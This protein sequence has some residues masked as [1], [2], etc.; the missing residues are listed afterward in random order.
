MDQPIFWSGPLL[1]G[2]LTWL[3]LRLLAP[4]ATRL[5]LLD[6]PVGRKDH[7]H[8]TPITGGIAMAVAVVVAGLTTLTTISQAF[9]GFMAAGL[10]LVI[11]GLLDDKYDLRWWIRV[12]AQVVAA[13][14][15]V[16][17]GDV[18]VLEVSEAFGIDTGWSLGWLSVP[19]TV[20]ATVGLINAVNMV[21]GVDGLAGSL[22][23]AALS[24]F[25]VAALYSGNL[26][27]GERA[28]VLAGAVAGFLYYNLRMPWR[29]KAT[30]FMGNAGSA[31]LGFAIAWIAF[32]L[33]QSPSH[34]VNPVL[35]LWLVPVP[36]MDCLVLL[37]R[38]ARQRKSPFSADRDHIHHLMLD[39]GFS[40]TQICG[41]LVVF[42]G[43]CGLVAGQAMRAN[44]PHPVILATFLVMCMAWYWTTSRRVRAVG[45]L[46]SVHAHGFFGAR[47]PSLDRE[48]APL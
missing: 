35:A 21:D 8:P 37:V 47:I 39:A 10:L 27:I 38:R 14:I 34:P 9:F 33:T 16:Y 30:L 29:P 2:A 40:P 15:M 32:R 13:L 22:V 48:P 7:G 3:V 31:F 1:A 45:F 24:M 25:A 12:L 18:R 28:L 6:H 46:R 5:N 19:F 36:V 23:F 17:V 44:V 4:V 42:S 11:V 43:I 41:T 20:F 26:M